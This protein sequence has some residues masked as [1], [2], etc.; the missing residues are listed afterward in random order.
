MLLFLSAI[1][2]I[3]NYSIWKWNILLSWSAWDLVQSKR[4]RFFPLFHFFFFCSLA[5]SDSGILLLPLEVCLSSI[6]IVFDAII[7]SDDCC[8]LSFVFLRLTM[9]KQCNKRKHLHFYGIDNIRT[10]RHILN[11]MTIFLLDSW[12]REC[13]YVCVAEKTNRVVSVF[14]SAHMKLQR[15]EALQFMSDYFILCI[16]VQ[17]AAVDASF[18]WMC[19]PSDATNGQ[20]KKNFCTIH[21]EREG[22]LGAFFPFS[23]RLQN[24]SIPNST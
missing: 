7:Y 24:D 16:Y 15:C 9:A 11:S 18:Y 14:K 12:T 4:F 21:R 20:K 10:A 6:W 5:L 13:V 23:Q 19:A 3:T 22:D 8:S 1:I 17:L 2:A